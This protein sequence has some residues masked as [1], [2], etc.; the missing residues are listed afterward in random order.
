VGHLSAG[1]IV[2]GRT[3]DIEMRAEDLYVSTKE[4]RVRY[5]FFNKA[6][7]DIA[8][9]VA[10]PMP[11]IEAP[12]DMNSRVIPVEDSPNFLGF[13]TQVDGKPVTI[14]LEQ[15]AVALGIDRTDM[16]KSLN[17]PLANF[18]E[19]T[20]TALAALPAD[21]QAELVRLGIARVEEYDIGQGM[22]KHTLPD[23]TLRTTYYWIQTF[24]AGKEIVVE[25]QYQPSV[26]GSVA[27]SVATTPEAAE[28]NR[29]RYC[30][31][32][33]IENAAKR[34]RAELKRGPNGKELSERRL[35]YVLV[36]GAHWAGPIKDFRLVIDKL[37]P[38]HIISACGKFKRISATQFELRETDFYP[39]RNL[40]VLV[41]EPLQ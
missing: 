17:L 27:T 40:E 36:T 29:R 31:D 12:S 5:R 20:K 21:K 7:R 34:R 35:E 10:F 39:L 8:T 2:L 26:G 25:H 19:A 30:V 4:I 16:L 9:L 33:E 11:D 18:M 24:P 41:L 15:R 32:R 38:G 14:Q 22:K 37:D 1:G 23:W 28:E 13:R 6:D 3:D